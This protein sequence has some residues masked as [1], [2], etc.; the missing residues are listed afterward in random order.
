MGSRTGIVCFVKGCRLHY[1]LDTANRHLVCATTDTVGFASF[2]IVDDSLWSEPIKIQG[3]IPSGVIVL[4]KKRPFS[5]RGAE[6]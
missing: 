4:T 2:G 1:D 5:M 6:D 3:K